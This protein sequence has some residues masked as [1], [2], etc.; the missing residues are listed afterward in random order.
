MKQTKKKNMQERN[1]IG[2]FLEKT[3]LFWRWV[4]LVYFICTDCLIMTIDNKKKKKK[5]K[6]KKNMNGV[7]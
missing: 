2:N 5:K 3:S 6:K 7:Q 4:D 1:F